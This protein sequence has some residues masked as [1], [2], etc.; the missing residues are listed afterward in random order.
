[1]GLQCI[2]P[3]FSG[4]LNYYYENTEGG[5]GD[6]ANNRQEARVQAQIYT[7]FAERVGVNAE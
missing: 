1:M 3:H 6:A 4:K 7:C 2:R 5:H